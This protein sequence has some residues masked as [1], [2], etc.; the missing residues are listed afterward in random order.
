MAPH[1]PKAT[2]REI[3]AAVD[4]RLAKLR[5]RMVQDGAPASEAA[6]VSQARGLRERQ[7]TTHQGKTLRL[8]RSYTRGPTCQSGLCP[9]R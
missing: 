2:R 9:P 4:E 3:E 8:R 6:E 1:H 5:A 7:V